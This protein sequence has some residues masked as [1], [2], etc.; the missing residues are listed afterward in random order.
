MKVT[1]YLAEVFIVLLLI[2]TGAKAQVK[3]IGMKLGGHLCSRCSF[4]IRKAVS[5]LDFGP[6]SEEVKITDFS[7]GLS[8]FAPKSEKPVRF[9][10]L[11]SALKKAGFKLISADIT[12]L[13]KLS[14]DDS[15]WWIE[16]GVS[17]QRFELAGDAPGAEVEK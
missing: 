15:G 5:L 7:Q 16:A 10:D 13:G 4:N 6:K 2:T 11:K 12:V 9:A 1:K 14:H 8:E 3:S 17:R